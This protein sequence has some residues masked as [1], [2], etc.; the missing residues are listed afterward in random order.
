MVRD[1]AGRQDMVRLSGQMGVPVILVNGTV[2]VGFDRNRLA[3]ALEKGGGRARE[4]D[5]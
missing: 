3:A 4:G 2:I 1:M 5:G